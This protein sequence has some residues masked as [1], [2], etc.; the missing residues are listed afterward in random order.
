MEDWYIR[1]TKAIPFGLNKINVFKDNKYAKLEK[2]FEFELKERRMLIDDALATER[3]KGAKM[4]KE[5]DDL[6]LEN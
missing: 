4:E 5:I 6:K 2:H 1:N 3:E